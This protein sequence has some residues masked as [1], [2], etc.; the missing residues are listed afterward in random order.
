M[1]NNAPPPA[2]ELPKTLGAAATREE[3][4]PRYSS[5]NTLL[6]F[7]CSDEVIPSIVNS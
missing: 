6:M 5:S 7:S 4:L 1:V 3:M 2:A